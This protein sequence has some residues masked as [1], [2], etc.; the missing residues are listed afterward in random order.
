[1]GY[2]MKKYERIYNKI[3]NNKKMKKICIICI[4]MLIF[5]ISAFSVNRILNYKKNKAVI[6]SRTT[7]NSQVNFDKDTM[8]RK[9][10]GKL[11]TA[12]RANIHGMNSNTGEFKPWEHKND[13]KKIAYL[14][15]DDGPSP[16]NTPK[17]LDI[18]KQNNIKATFFLI[19]S[20]AEKNKELVKREVDE[21]HT[22]GNHT[23]SHQLNYA[24]GPEN[25]LEDV[26]KC[27]N[28]LESIIGQEYNLKL[29]RFPGGS[30]NTKT[31]NLAPFREVVT[32]AG[33]EYVNWDDWIGDAEHNNV[34]VNNLLDELR[35]YTVHNHTIVLM[36]DAATKDTTVE[37]LPQVIE[38]LKSKGY[39]FD[40]IR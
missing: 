26:N 33:Y 3:N 24:E 34:P 13:G 7:N 17:V 23:Y 12:F 22:I 40:T 14:T 25:F 21:G 6:A 20:Y 2:S 10:E 28:V 35:K 11:R 36:H 9:A 8:E 27:R 30:W 19:G 16:N 39:S 1:M 5:G 29:L 31:L 18:L 37:A 38:Y 4:I 32:N 15:F